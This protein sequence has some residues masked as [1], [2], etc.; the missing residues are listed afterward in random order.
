MDITQRGLIRLLNRGTSLPV[1]L[2]RLLVASDM[3]WLPSRQSLSAVLFQPPEASRGFSR[4]VTHTLLVGCHP[5]AVAGEA[6]LPG[7]GRGF[8][9]LGF[10]SVQSENP[11]ISVP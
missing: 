11:R 7:A 2:A 5:V 3:E 8:D 10:E 1:F 4:E 9:V 6:W